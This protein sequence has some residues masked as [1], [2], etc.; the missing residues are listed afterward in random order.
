M[1]QFDFTYELP[2]NFNSSLIQF[3]QQNRSTDVAQAFQRCKYE[4]QDLG[5]AYYAG[6]EEILGTK[7]RLTLLLRVQKK[8]LVYL[9]QETNF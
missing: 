6:L 1:G 8:I 5:L 7:K 3:L 4:Y 9:N 2:N